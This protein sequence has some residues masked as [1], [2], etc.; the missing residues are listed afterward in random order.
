MRSKLFVG[1]MPILAVALATAAACSQAPQS[2]LSPSATSIVALGDSASV[3][4]LKVAAPVPMSPIGGATIEGRKPTFVFANSAGRF[5]VP[6]ENG[7]YEIEV[8]GPNGGLV[9]RHSV[10]GNPGGGTSLTHPEDLAWESTFT[11]R[12]RKTLEGASGPW[13]D[14]VSFR[15][16]DEP[17]AKLGFAIPASCGAQN[18]PNGNRLACAYDVSLLSSEWP[19]CRSGSGV[20]C[21]RYTRHLAAAL[22][23]GDPRWGLITKNANEQQCTWD[24]CGQSVRGGYGEDVVSFDRGG[25]GFN[26]EGWDVVVGAGAP[27]AQANWTRLDGRRPGNNWAPVP[28]FP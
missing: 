14:T 22:A 28:P 4:T 16:P 1:R 2:P 11:W 25:G 6:G 8:Y 24:S 5:I 27:G 10:D 7:V 18:P 13:S 23:T 17:K 3:A 26:W 15:T 12:V 19:G 20:R 21:H 9:V